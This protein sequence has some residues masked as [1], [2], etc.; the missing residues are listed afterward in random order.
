MAQISLDS[1]NVFG[2]DGGV[3]QLGT[4][5]GSIDGG[6]AVILDVPVSAS[7]QQDSSMGGG[8][9]PAPPPGS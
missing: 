4:V 5:T 3:D 2:E 9:G 1:D 6:L 8:D 7:T